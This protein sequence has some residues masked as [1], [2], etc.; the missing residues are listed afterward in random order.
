MTPFAQE[1][2]SSLDQT[3]DRKKNVD[4]LDRMSDHSEDEPHEPISGQEVMKSGKFKD[5]ATMKV[6]YVSDKKYLKW[7]RNNIKMD[8]GEDMR[9]YRLYVEMRDQ[10]KEARIQQ[11][12]NL[13]TAQMPGV[14]AQMPVGNPRLNQ[15]YPGATPKAK[16]KAKSMAA[17]SSS[18]MPIPMTPDSRGHRRAREGD[19][20]ATELSGLQM[21]TETTIKYEIDRI[22]EAQLKETWNQMVALQEWENPELKVQM[23]EVAHIMGVE[24]AVKMFRYLEED[25]EP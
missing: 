18:V 9:R 13:Q 10:M 6:A 4:I 15:G 23:L 3:E 20:W 11:Q 7:V 2:L 17:A 16:A 21:D 19:G 14:N 1:M 24:K 12:V 22:Q 25:E 5:R 8:S